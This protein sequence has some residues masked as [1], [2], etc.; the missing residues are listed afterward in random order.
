MQ[1]SLLP[2]HGQKLSLRTCDGDF[3]GVQ[4]TSFTKKPQKILQIINNICPLMELFPQIKADCQACSNLALIG[5]PL[6]KNPCLTL[7]YGRRTADARLTAPS[8][9]MHIFNKNGGI[10]FTRKHS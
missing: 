8:Q 2:L 10:V 9:L 3:P 6:T 4:N 1:V 5:T 7:C